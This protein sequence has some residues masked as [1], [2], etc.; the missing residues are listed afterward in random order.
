VVTAKYELGTDTVT[1]WVIWRSSSTEVAWVDYQGLC[2]A[3]SFG[4]ATIKATYEGRVDE[5]LVTVE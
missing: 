3:E 5:A 4:E 2:T 1:D